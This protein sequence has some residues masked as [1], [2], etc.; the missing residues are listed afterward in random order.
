MGNHIEVN[1]IHIKPF[2]WPSHIAHAGWIEG[3]KAEIRRGHLD[4]LSLPL[5]ED[6]ITEDE[7]QRISAIYRQID[8]FR[9][10]DDSPASQDTCLLPKKWE[11]KIEKNGVWIEV[12]RRIQIAYTHLEQLPDT[13]E[14]TQKAVALSCAVMEVLYKR[15]E[16]TIPSLYPPQILALLRAADNLEDPSNRGLFEEIVS[17]EGKTSVDIRA[18][19]PI[20]MLKGRH[21]DIIS[22]TPFATEDMQT[23]YDPIARVFG[24][25]LATVDPLN[26]PGTF[27]IRK[28]DQRG[29]V[30]GGNIYAKNGRGV[31]PD[32]AEALHGRSIVI[33]SNVTVRHLALAEPSLLRPEPQRKN[34]SAPKSSTNP[35]YQYSVIA[36]PDEW[37]SP[38]VDTQDNAAASGSTQVDFSGEILRGWRPWKRTVAPPD[39]AMMEKLKQSVGIPRIE[40]ATRQLM[41]NIHLKKKKEKLPPQPTID[42][43]KARIE[44]YIEEQRSTITN[45][46]DEM[47]RYAYKA[48][49]NE[50]ARWN[51]G[52]KKAIEDRYVLMQLLF[53]CYD[54]M[55][56]RIPYIDRDHQTAYF[57]PDGTLGEQGWIN[58]ARRMLHTLNLVPYPD[59]VP[60]ETLYKYITQDVFPDHVR[61]AINQAIQYRNGMYADTQVF[62]GTPQLMATGKMMGTEQIVNLYRPTIEGKATTIHLKDRESGFPEANTTLPPMIMLALTAWTGLRNP[63]VVLPATATVHQNT[64]SFQEYMT[65]RPE[66]TI[67]FSGTGADPVLRDFYRQQYGMETTRIPGWKENRLIVNDPIPKKNLNEKIAWLKSY[68]ERQSQSV[69]HLLIDATTEEEYLA[70]TAVLKDI[71]G[72]PDDQKQKTI[73][74][75]FGRDSTARQAGKMFTK[76]GIDGGIMVA[77]RLAGREIDIPG[78]ELTVICLSPRDSLRQQSQVIRRAGRNG[79]TGYAY[80]LYSPHDEV[81]RNIP[82]DVRPTFDV[83][84]G[85][86]PRLSLQEL[87]HRGWNPQRLL[88]EAYQTNEQI[89]VKGIAD[90]QKSWMHIMHARAHTLSLDPT[91]YNIDRIW[92]YWPLINTYIGHLY[93]MRHTYSGLGSKDETIFQRLVDMYTR[94]AIE[95]IATVPKNKAN[96]QTIER[97]FYLHLVERP[98]QEFGLT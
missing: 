34:P 78:E 27:S 38:T 79:K 9:S 77:L 33:A 80:I 26:E 48:G 70:V 30:M 96:P 54:D 66:K 8:I 92:Q 98:T 69:F 22:R 43:V 45:V 64:M 1:Q 72:D 28:Y 12:Q 90:A 44:Q 74:L 65:L 41:E 68:I 73:P 15:G 87:L 67:A 17:G 58:I 93:T 63:N 91:I 49:R 47:E 7:S 94:N 84:E 62:Y 6:R 24:F 18:L 16:T 5:P 89:M 36:I 46:T 56:S 31:H 53:S 39:P 32:L 21:I 50:R 81:F 29:E 37:D 55:C 76:L 82:F 23:K 52:R 35:T 57:R 88:M 97:L 13:P 10:G 61:D 42:E 2:E 71:Y 95:A 3:K 83:T 4:W 40:D 11:E 19:I 86:S 59:V 85:V 14:R 60:D 51:M 75:Y 20:A 25:S